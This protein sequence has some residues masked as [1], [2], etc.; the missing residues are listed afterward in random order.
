MI[1]ID[2]LIY[3][4]S[5]DTEMITDRNKLQFVTIQWLCCLLMMWMTAVSA[6]QTPAQ[7]QQQQQT[8]QLQQ[9]QTQQQQQTTE[10]SP[11]AVASQDA[12]GRFEETRRFTSHTI[13]HTHIHTHLTTH[14]H[15]HS[16][17]D[18]LFGVSIRETRIPLVR[19]VRQK[20]ADFF[21]SPKMMI[22]NR[23]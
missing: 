17:I 15:T 14:T 2:I 23:K 13:P 22:V 1:Y 7:R 3:F 12:T 16:H 18:S 19:F 6:T 10:Q 20:D 21:N 4:R 9:Q 5:P 11:P 8:Q